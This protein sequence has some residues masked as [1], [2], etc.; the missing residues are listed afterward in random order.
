[1]R[2][3]KARRNCDELVMP[4][5]GVKKIQGLE[6]YTNLEVLRLNKNRITGVALIYNAIAPMM[7]LWCSHRQL[8]T[9]LQ[10]P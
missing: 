1:M 8:G 2:S 10:A 6:Q 5:C 7:I 9:R 3:L 4:E